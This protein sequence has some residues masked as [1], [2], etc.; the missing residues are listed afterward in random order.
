M[1]ELSSRSHLKLRNELW[2]FRGS[3]ARESRPQ[4]PKFYSLTTPESVLATA[5][6][7][8]ERD[9]LK[10]SFTATKVQQLMQGF[11]YLKHCVPGISVCYFALLLP[12]H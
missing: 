4:I 1:A 3:L 7:A 9:A 10:I 11:R 8:Q 2:I 6:T 5:S 12:F